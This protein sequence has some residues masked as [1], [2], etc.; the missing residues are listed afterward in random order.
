MRSRPRPI[1]ILV[2]SE[3]QS[4]SACAFG[5]L[6][7]APVKEETVAIEHDLGNLALLAELRDALAH[8]ARRALVAGRRAVESDGRRR[9]QRAAALVR[10][11][12]RVHVP[13]AA[14]DA[15]AWPLIR[16]LQAPAYPRLAALARHSLLR[17]RHPAIS[18]P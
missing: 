13:V 9:R 14:E 4:G 7:H 1:A 8:L 17:R 6:F 11:D 12:L 5:D 3:L 15:R 2:S 16:T 10:D 18:P